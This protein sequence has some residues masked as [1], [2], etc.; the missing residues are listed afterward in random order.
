MAEGA[1]GEVTRYFDPTG[2]VAVMVPP[3]PVAVPAL[4]VAG[5]YFDPSRPILRYQY[6]DA[7]EIRSEL[8]RLDL[9]TVRALDGL[10]AP[11]ESVEENCWRRWGFVGR[12]GGCGA[13]GN[14]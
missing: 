7:E 14:G 6:P 1:R 12:C 9:W 10:T 13:L 2:R 4:V 3:A 5:G 11:G 8:S